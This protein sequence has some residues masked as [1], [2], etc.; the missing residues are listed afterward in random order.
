M[1]TL[2]LNDKTMIQGVAPAQAFAYFDAEDAFLY[3]TDDRDNF[4]NLAARA[5]HMLAPFHEIPEWQGLLMTFLDTAEDNGNRQFIFQVEQHPNFAMVLLRVPRV[6]PAT[7]EDFNDFSN[8]VYTLLF[9]LPL[10]PRTDADTDDEEESEDQDP[11][12]TQTQSPSE[13]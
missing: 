6:R 2:I 9:M 7:L 1:S 5:F 3:E 11:C 4:H 12:S 13:T 8:A 10:L